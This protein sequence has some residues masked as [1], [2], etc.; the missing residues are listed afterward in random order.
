[1]YCVGVPLF[2]KPFQT[3]DFLRCAKNPLWKKIMFTQTSLLN[4]PRKLIQR[5]ASL[6]CLSMTEERG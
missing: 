4:F 1:M 2:K 3:P 6:Y 5:Q